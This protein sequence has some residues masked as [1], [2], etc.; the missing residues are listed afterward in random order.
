[1][2]TIVIT[3]LLGLAGSVFAQDVSFSRKDIIDMSIDATISNACAQNIISCLNITAAACEADVRI[4]LAN[5][6]ANKV[7][8]TVSDMEKLPEY[9]GQLAG[10]TVKALLSKHNSRM[11]QNINS[12]ACQSLRE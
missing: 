6:C 3:A 4:L 5:K 1:M 8:E 11:Q 7:P 9:A 12:P 2:K 10:C